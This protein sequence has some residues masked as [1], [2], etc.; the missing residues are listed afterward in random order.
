[1]R[2]HE[3]EYA[4]SPGRIP[5]AWILKVN[6]DVRLHELY[7][8]VGDEGILRGPNVWYMVRLMISDTAH[9]HNNACMQ[10]QE[11]TEVHFH[12]KA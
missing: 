10:D 8:Y 9:F 2:E 4:K 5:S 11:D 12:D 3:Q 1:M 7:Y 6:R